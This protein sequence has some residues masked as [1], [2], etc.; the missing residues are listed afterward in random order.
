MNVFRSP[1]LVRSGIPT[2]PIGS[3]CLLSPTSMFSPDSSMEDEDHDLSDLEDLPRQ[4]GDADD[5]DVDQN[6]LLD[7]SETPEDGESV[8][9][10]ML[11]EMIFNEAPILLQQISQHKVDSELVSHREADSELMSTLIVEGPEQLKHEDPVVNVLDDQQ[12]QT[13]QNAVDP[14]LVQKSIEL[15]NAFTPQTPGHVDVVLALTTFYQKRGILMKM[16]DHFMDHK[17]GNNT[18]WASFTCPLN[19]VEYTSGLPLPLFLPGPLD[20]RLVALTSKMFGNYT[21]QKDQVAFSTKKGAKRAVAF[22]VLEA[23]KATGVDGNLIVSAIES[24]EGTEDETGS[25]KKGS[26]HRSGN[27]PGWLHELHSMGVDANSLEISYRECFSRRELLSPCQLCCVLKVRKP[28]QLIA[29]SLPC[30]SKR[31]AVE[32]AVMVLSEEL[33]RTETVLPKPNTSM[34]EMSKLHKCDPLSAVYVKALPPWAN[35]SVHGKLYVYRLRFFTTVGTDFVASRSGLSMDILTPLGIAFVAPLHNVVTNREK[36]RAQFEL[37]TPDKKK[38]ERVFV[39]ISHP[40]MVDCADGTQESADVLD[41]IRYF[42]ERVYCWKD[43]GHQSVP[44]KSTNSASLL[45]RTYMF[46]PLLKGEP[47]SVAIDW[48]LLRQI[49]EHQKIPFLKTLD[50]EWKVPVV[51]KVD[52]HFLCALFASI[53]L[54]ILIP[55]LMTILPRLLEGNLTFDPGLIFH[56]L[57]W[58][59]LLLACTSLVTL[60]VFVV[61]PPSILID[62]KILLNRFMIERKPGPRRLYVTPSKDHC[63]NPLNFVQSRLSGRC[64][65]MKP[66]GGTLVQSVVEA[67]LRKF[68]LDLRTASFAMLYSKKFGIKVR[69]PSQKLLNGVHVGKHPEQDFLFLSKKERFMHL[70]PELVEVLPM[71][72][73]AMYI[74]KHA[75]AFMPA[76]E[77]AIELEHLT[78]GMHT[79]LKSLSSRAPANWQGSSVQICTQRFGGLLDEA[80]TVTKYQRLE[81]LGDAVLGFF[82][83]LNLMS[84]NSSLT[85]DNDDLSMIFTDACKNSTLYDG[86]LRIGVG[87][88]VRTQN[89][90][91]ASIF[92]AKP[93][94]FPTPVHATIQSI[95]CSRAC[96]FQLIDATDKI[97]SDIVESLLGA[98]FLAEEQGDSSLLIGLLEGLRL[99][100]PTRESECDSSVPPWFRATSPCFRQ[101][102]MFERDAA[103]NAQIDAIGTAINS[104]RDV[105]AKLEAGFLGL[106]GLLVTLSG[107]EVLLEKLSNQQ[108]KTLLMCSLFDDSLDDFEASNTPQEMPRSFAGSNINSAKADGT[109]QTERSG[110]ENGIFRAALLRD[111]LGMVGSYAL[112][113]CITNELYHRY[114]NVNEHSLHIL[115]V[116]AMADDVAVYIMFKAGIHKFLLDQRAEGIGE[117]QFIMEM[118]D[119]LGKA[120]WLKLN[121]WILPGGVLEYASR[122]QKPWKGTDGPTPRY[123]GLGGG[124]LVGRKQKVPESITSDFMFSMKSIIG[125]LVLSIGVDGMWRCIGPL[126]EEVMLLSIDELR[127]VYP[128]SSII[129]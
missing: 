50:Q 30:P 97:L 114:P 124:R 78:V 85:W 8:D 113:L 120:E 119:V 28:R 54:A 3:G 123:C 71:P 49:N 122:W 110:F 43:Y 22:A 90:I 15:L 26:K 35:G 16:A 89:D 33:K 59:G 55:D 4:G 39:E 36:F 112:Q 18:F 83:A 96:D 5:D 34:N 92:L 104:D 100:M 64:P 9:D 129:R 107:D 76:L 70:M 56:G 84:L 40:T 23:H 111:T 80:L 57:N 2:T 52:V 73:D 81:F 117:F 1:S 27:L 68:N 116:C 31:A 94:A 109:A 79:S 127:R 19:G 48:S 38:Y 106:T 105:S 14:T 95:T 74:L 42:N 24:N 13:Q 61:Y 121:G 60:L 108:S 93:A 103:W 21:I 99:P 86:A 63:Q 46:V 53:S 66:N 25:T 98:V 101:G 32:N 20:D 77:R 47:E 82:L 17:S 67:N 58:L 126:F 41:H 37:H 102:Y 11:E 91:W 65:V 75:C 44:E 87:S 88:L 125:A 12:L 69:C 72:R 62:K 118:A 51:G 6:D 115:R 128:N 29:I 10:E 45:D 7:L